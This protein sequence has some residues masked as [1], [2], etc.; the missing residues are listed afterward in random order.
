MGEATQL[1]SPRPLTDEAFYMGWNARTSVFNGTFSCCSFG[2][3]VKSMVDGVEVTTT[4]PCDKLRIKP[5]VEALWDRKIEHEKSMPLEV[6]GMSLWRWI[7]H[8]HF[9]LTD[10]GE[11][12]GEEDGGGEEVGCAAQIQ[13]CI[14]SRTSR[15]STGC[16]RMEWRGWCGT[17][18]GC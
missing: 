17:S 13:A 5:M 1:P 3:R 7:S 12:R 2:H 15:K 14:R 4:I 11:G 16:C 9:M 18:S 6:R 8:K 10:S